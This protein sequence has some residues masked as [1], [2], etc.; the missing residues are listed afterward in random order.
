[1]LR[2]KNG[3]RD[4][5]EDYSVVTS[6]MDKNQFKLVYGNERKDSTDS[7]D[8]DRRLKKYKEPDAWSPHTSMTLSTV[9]SKR[10]QT[11]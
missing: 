2:Y 9:A 8:E 1:M 7:N 5:Q 6:Q 3:V 10:F 4:L 11:L